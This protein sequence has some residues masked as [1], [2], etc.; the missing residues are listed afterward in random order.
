[1][2][3]PKSEKQPNSATR[4]RKA[5]ERPLDPFAIPGGLMSMPLVMHVT[6]ASRSSI[7]AWMQEGHFPKPRKLGN[8]RV[9]WLASDVQRWINERPMAA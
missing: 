2:A 3:Q 5:A 1:M 4:N 6:A 7:Y 9:A 8:K